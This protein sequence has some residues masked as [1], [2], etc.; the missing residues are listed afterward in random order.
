[1][2]QQALDFT[3]LDVWKWWLVPTGIALSLTL[4]GLSFMGYS[5]ET[6]LNPRLSKDS[7]AEGGRC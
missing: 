6:A 1:M 7:P 4:M 2:M 3:Y 5:Q